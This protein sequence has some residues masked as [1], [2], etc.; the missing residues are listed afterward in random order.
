MHAAGIV[1]RIID[2]TRDRIDD[3]LID[4]RRIRAFTLRTGLFDLEEAD[5]DL[6]RIALTDAHEQTL[7]QPLKVGR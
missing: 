6:V 3:H 4:H 5:D 2:R 1:G 7:D